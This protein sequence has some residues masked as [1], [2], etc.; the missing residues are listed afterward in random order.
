MNIRKLI[1]S[2]KDQM[3]TLMEEFSM[4]HH[5]Q[6]LL[7]GEIKEIAA[8]KNPFEQMKIELGQ[9]FNLHTYVAEQDGKL[10]GFV[11]GQITNE[12][13]RILDKIGY[14]EELFV[15]ENAR[16]LKLGQSL[17]ETIL[18]VLKTE[19]CTVYR[20]SAYVNNTVAINLYRKFGFIDDSLELSRKVNK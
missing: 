9:Y 15:T 2:D 8:L 14:I 7:S 10:L 6:Q 20:T 16:G 17:M 5:R 3:L 18:N 12:P 4:K 1:Q 13:D 19:G 11:V